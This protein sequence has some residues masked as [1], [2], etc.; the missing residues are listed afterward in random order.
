MKLKVCSSKED[1]IL[2]FTSAHPSRNN[3]FC[4]QGSQF[5][6]LDIIMC[7]FDYIV[8]YTNVGLSIV[9]TKKLLNHHF[10][11]SQIS[12]HYYQILQS[13]FGFNCV[14]GVWLSGNPQKQNGC[15]IQ[16]AM[17]WK[18]ISVHKPTLSL[19][20]DLP[21]NFD[22]HKVAGPLCIMGNSH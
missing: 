18:L 3:F 10:Q 5:G 9:F 19:S 6:H 11:I 15:P 22:V 16:C 4:M 14:S 21:V 7:C 20:K 17:L 13:I 2:K 12:C 8:L 1:K